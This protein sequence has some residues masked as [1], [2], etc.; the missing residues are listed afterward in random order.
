MREKKKTEEG[1]KEI[2]Y[3]YS[4]S[5]CSGTKEEEKREGGEEGG[6]KERGQSNPLGLSR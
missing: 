2:S 1:G 5:R 6:R 4:N 3:K